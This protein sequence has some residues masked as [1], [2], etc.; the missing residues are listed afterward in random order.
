VEKLTGTPHDDF[1]SG[2]DEP[3]LGDGNEIGPQEG[4]NNL[5]SKTC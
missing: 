4:G 5:L 1:D 2:L 3:V